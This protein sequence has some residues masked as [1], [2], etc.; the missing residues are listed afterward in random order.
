MDGTAG[1]ELEE[2]IAS[3]VVNENTTLRGLENA[4]FTPTGPPRCG[5]ILL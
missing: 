4:L 5:N 3:Q 2:D 1:A